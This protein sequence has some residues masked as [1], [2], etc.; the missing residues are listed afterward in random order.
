MSRQDLSR[1][2]LLTRGVALTAMLAAGCNSDG[3]PTT[4][5]DAT[6]TTT[7]TATETPTETPTETETETDTPTP[8]PLPAPAGRPDRWIHPGHNAFQTNAGAAPGP[9]DGV[10]Q[11]WVVNETVAR[12]RLI[13]RNQPVVAEGRVFVPQRTTSSGSLLAY[14]AATGE[15]LWKSSNQVGAGP[16]YYDG[17]VIV[18]ENETE[19]SPAMTTLD[20]A[21]GEQTDRTL[22]NLYEFVDVVYD[23]ANDQFVLLEA[24]REDQT[25]VRGVDPNSGA[26]RW[27]RAIDGV[28]E[29]G[30]P[31][32]VTVIDGTLFV[33]RMAR[34]S[35]SSRLDPSNSRLMALDPAS[36]AFRW[37]ESVGE[38]LLAGA[39]DQLY[40]LTLDSTWNVTGLAARSMADGER[41]W[42]VSSGSKRPQTQAV[43]ATTDRVLV[44]G[45]QSLTALDPATGDIDWAASLGDRGLGGP[46]MG[47]NDAYVS[48]PSRFYSFDAETGDQTGRV[49][50]DTQYTNTSTEGEHAIAVAGDQAYA[51]LSS[52]LY[53]FE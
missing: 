15:R 45:E 2:Q 22:V 10:S 41:R 34:P 44:V 3:E 13:P 50:L 27:E 40:L 19:T 52:G 25:R 6:P 33:T 38:T 4:T 8:E 14:D 17:S 46:V 30:V 11:N 29:A 31:L 51:A 23:A 47:A 42:E 36:G 16:V 20:P 53:A 43:A 7:M 37:S 5:T 24:I 35:G 18:F 48:T 32:R 9:P 21:S 39:G 12:N 1:R 28:R 26:T 49:Q